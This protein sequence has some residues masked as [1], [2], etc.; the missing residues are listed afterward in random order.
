MNIF[1]IFLGA[2][3]GG[4]L[5]YWSS[6][7]VYRLLGRQFPFGTLLV[8]SMGCFLMGLLYIVIL[9]RSG[10]FAPQLRSLILIGFLGGYTTFSTFSIETFNL[11]EQAQTFKALLNI[12]CS[13]GLC[14]G[15][16]WAGIFL[17]R[18]L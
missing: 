4:V 5:R 18:R 16:T 3:F 10:R 11:Y 15:L 14:L 6:I 1:L 8:N 2:G 13:I 7:G 12:I 17:G 9:E